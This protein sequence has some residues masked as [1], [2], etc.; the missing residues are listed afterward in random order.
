VSGDS[1]ARTITVE[2]PA[3]TA[4]LGAGF[5][6]LALALDLVNEITVA[7]ALDLPPGE[8]FTDALGEGAA[9]LSGG[10][11][12]RFTEA[13]LG[14]V[15]EVEHGWH[16]EMRNAIP[17]ARGLGSSAAAT[18]AG[19]VAGRALRTDRVISDD[20][21]LTI[22][23]RLEGHP[24]NAAASL[25]GGFVV[26]IATSD[27]PSVARFEPPSGLIVV[28]FIP[29]RQLPTAEMR[30]VLPAEVPREDAVH[31]VGRAAIAVAAFA[32]G[33]LE[34]LG[35]ATEDRLHE[36][37]RAA[38][39][40]ALPA[41]VQAARQAGALGACLSGAGSTIIAFADSPALAEAVSRALS[42]EAQRSGLDG[43]PLVARPRPMGAVVCRPDR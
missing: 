33:R 34:L 32:T 39:F 31:N 18:V 41:M 11:A 29:D 38:V 3:S 23:T 14:S 26:A 15:G 16:V 28:L 6:V 10:R 20:D 43:R 5:D 25:L 4:N 30:A 9:E 22:A 8:V 13:F 40:P 12:N 36:P 35:A 37:Y 27:G 7:P 17:L 24:E 1:I 21:L 2:V 42:T 19:L